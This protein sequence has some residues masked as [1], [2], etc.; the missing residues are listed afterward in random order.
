MLLPDMLYQLDVRFT[1][2]RRGNER[3]LTGDRG[4]GEKHTLDRQGRAQESG[5]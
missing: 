3:E 2:A 4:F 1:R 5:G